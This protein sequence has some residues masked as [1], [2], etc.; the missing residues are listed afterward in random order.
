MYCESS[1]DNFHCK[2]LQHLQRRYLPKKHRKC[3]FFEGKWA[4]QEAFYCGLLRKVYNVAA[5]HARARVCVLP[6]L[7]KSPFKTYFLNIPLLMR[8]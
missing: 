1:T 5:K 3:R 8:N 4:A 7:I 2:G 6:L